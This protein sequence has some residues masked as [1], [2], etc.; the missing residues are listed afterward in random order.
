MDRS[1]VC[2]GDDASGQNRAPLGPFVLVS[3][4]ELHTCGLKSDG[5]V[6]CWGG[7][8][9]GQTNAPSGTFL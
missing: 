9:A 4:G 1:V 5:T 3:W 6:T 8:G 7:N 2:W